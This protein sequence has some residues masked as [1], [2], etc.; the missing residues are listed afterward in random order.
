[1]DDNQRK[2]LLLSVM[3]GL[4]V[5]V[6]VVFIATIFLRSSSAK[7]R[8]EKKTSELAK[9]EKLAYEIGQKKVETAEFENRISN[10]FPVLTHLENLTKNA[11]LP[12]PS[13]KNRPGA[14]SDYFE[15]SSWEL[16]LDKLNLKQVMALLSAVENSRPPRYLKVRYM[17]IK[18]PY[19]NK[20]LLNITILV[21]AFFPKE[22]EEPTPPK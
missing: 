22:I 20:E 7:A 2:Q 9:I 12:K 3:G 18:T 10:K 19:S 4:F 13:I 15:E 5:I 21:S 14:E 1:M 6:I 11:G 16:K 8:V 17:S